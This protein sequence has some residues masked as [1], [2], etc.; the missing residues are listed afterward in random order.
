MAVLRVVRVAEVVV[1][2]QTVVAG[3]LQLDS[4]CLQITAACCLEQFRPFWRLDRVLFLCEV[5]DDD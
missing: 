1:A 5:A 2:L 4:L 3:V